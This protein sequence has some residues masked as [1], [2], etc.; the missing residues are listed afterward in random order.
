MTDQ[1][2]R[3]LLLENNPDDVR[4]MRAA[5]HADEHQK[6]EVRQVGNLADGLAALSK[7]LPDAIL[8]NLEL[9]DSR[10]L[11]T[12]TCLQ[13]HVPQLPILVLAGSEDM[14]EAVRAVQSGAQDFLSKDEITGS[15]LQRSI[16]YALERKQ[17]IEALR[18][19]EER[20]RLMFENT[21]VGYHSLDEHGHILD[22]NDTW[23]EMLGYTRDEVL[24]R[25]FGDFLIPYQVPLFKKRF[26]I[27]IQSRKVIHDVDY[28]LQRKDGSSLDVVF[29]IQISRD[30]AGKFIRTYCGFL[31]VT[32]RK[33]ATNR[34]EIIYQ[35]LRSVNGQLDVHSLSQA[36]ANTIVRL[37]NYPHVCVT[38]LD[39]EHTSW[40]VSGAAGRLAAELGAVYPIHE[41]VI[42]RAFKTGKTQRV[43]DIL[44]DPNYVRDVSTSKAPA[45]RSEMVTLFRH[46][47]NILGALN[48]ESEQVN[49]FSDEDVILIE[50]L[51]DVIAL[52]LDNASLYEEAQQDILQRKQTE[53]ELKNSHSLL[54]ATLE[55]TAEGILVVDLKGNIVR[56][57]NKYMEIWNIPAAIL[58]K[59]K[60]EGILAHIKKLVIDPQS[61]ISSTHAIYADPTTGSFDSLELKNGRIIERLS[62]PHLLGGT[63]IGRV[64][65][66]RDV[67]ER[68]RV[69]E[70][71]AKLNKAVDSSNEVIFLTDLDGIITY[72]NP[73]F[74]NL[75]GYSAEEVV[76]K[77]TPRILK[78]GK[79][80]KEKYKD[81]WQTLL[82]EQTVIG[83]LVNKTRDGRL[84]TIESSV[85][86]IR[87]DQGNRIGFVA[88]QRDITQRKTLEEEIKR[89][90]EELERFFQ[91]MPDLVCIAS[92]D[93]YF[94]NLNSAWE[95]TLGFS[96]AELY[97]EPLASFIHPD[98]I[99]PTNLEIARQVA[100]N[101]TI[102]FINRYRCKDGSYKWL[103]WHA[104]PAVGGTDLYAV[105]RDITER[106][107]VEEALRE[108]ELQLRESQRVS[109]IGSYAM[110]LKADTWTSSEVLDELFGIP[111]NSEK[112]TTS[113]NDLVH[114][115]EK[116][117]MLD[118][119]LH[120]VIEAKKPFNKEYRIVRPG[121]GQVRWMWGLGSLSYDDNGTPLTMIGTIQDITE[122]KQAELELQ[123]SHSL[124]TTTI[125]STA[126]GILVVDLDGRISLANGRFANMWGIPQPVLD[127]HDDAAA[128]AY[129]MDKLKEP[130]DFIAKVQE[131]YATPAAESFDDIEFK[132]G[133]I[134]ERVSQPQ[135]QGDTI[136]GRVW[137]FRD[138]TERKQAEILQ[139][140]VYQ[141]SLAAETT[142]ALDDLYSTIH[143]IISSVMPSEN[144]YITLYDRRRDVL[145]FPYFKDTQDEPY[146]GEIQPGR[147]LTAYV[148]R[149]GKSLLCTQKVHD[150]LEH[151]G[152]IKLLG[153]PSAIWLGVPLIVE[154]KAIGVM[155]VQHY[156]DEKAYGLREQHMLEFVSTQV[157]IVISR[158]QAEQALHDSETQFRTLVEQLPAIVYI[159]DVTVGPGHT[160]YVSPQ[161]ET[162]LGITPGE[163]M[164][165][166][167]AVWLE[168]T[169]PGDHDRIL[170][171]YMRCYQDGEPVNSEY[172][173]VSSD[174][175]LVWI[176]D[177]A[178]LLRD[179]NGKPHSIHGVMYDITERKQA[180][181][182]QQAV[183]Q[184]ALATETT[185]SLDDLYPTIHEIITSVMPSENFYI[186]LFDEERNILNFPY[187]KDEVDEP[188][189]GE[190]KPGHGLTDYVLRTGKSLL[191]TQEVHDELE[192]KG[193]VKL[194]GVPSAIWLGVPL[195]ADEKVIGAM[196]V[197]HYT[198]AKAYGL[199]EQQM[200]EF[201]SSQV[202]IAIRRKQAEERL[203]LSEERFKQISENA[204]E[205]IWEVDNRGMYT[206][207]SPL[208][209]QK[210]GYTREEIVGKKHFYDFFTPDAR[211]NLKEAALAAFAMKQPFKDFINPNQHK[212]G[213]VVILETNGTP[214]LDRNGDLLGYRGAD[215][216]ITEREQAA[217]SLRSSEE[218]F[219]SLFNNMLEGY[220]YCQGIFEQGR[221]QDFIYLAVNDKFSELT[222]LNDVVGK[223]VSEV[224]PG[225]KETNP[226]I[227]D[228]YGRVALNG[229]PEKFESYFPN[230]EI[231]L[232]I[233][234]HSS[235]KGYFNAVIDNITEHKRSETLTRL[236]LVLL[237][238]SSSHSLE[239]ILQKTLDEVEDLTGSQ[240]GFY[241]F[242][243]QDQ[244]NLV[245][246]NWSTRTKNEFCKAEGQG[247]HYPTS[248]AG[249]WADCVFT[250]QPIIHNDYASLPNR[251][252][253]PEGHA[254]LI[255]ELVVP[256]LRGDKVVAVLGVGNKKTNYNDRDIEM[257]NYLADS[258]W[259]FVA[260]KMAENKIIESEA[261]YH[262][263]FDNVPDGV[264]RTTPEGKFLTVNQEAVRMLGF[265]S[266]EELMSA[267]ADQFY[268]DRE[269]RQK[270][271][272]IMEELGEVHN[273]EVHFRNKDG[274][275]M[276][277]LENAR[278]YRDENGKVLFYEG[279]LTDITERKKSET[280]RQTL[281]EI[282]QGLMVTDDLHDYLNVVH[283]AIAKVIYAENF[284]VILK[285]TETGLFED[286]YMV[287]QFDLPMPPY[288]LGKTLSAFVYRTGRPFL[289]D[290]ATFDLLVAQGEVEQVGTRSPS[291]LGVP[292]VASRETIGVMVVQ[293]YATKNRYTGHDVD[294]LTSIA[295]QVALAVKRKYAETELARMF[296]R[297]KRRVVRLSEL[298]VISA[299]LNSQHS[300]RELL[301]TLVL[302]AAALSNSPVSTIM[303]LDETNSEVILAEHT[304]L[305]N[306]IPPG[307]RIPIKALPEEVLAFQKGDPIIISNID[308]ELPS[309]RRVLVHPDV[310]SFSAYPLSIDGRVAGVFTLSNFAPHHPSDGEINA[311]QL[312]AR[313]ASA[314]LD[315]VRL[316]ES[317]NRNVKRLGS[318]RRVDMAI[319]S[320]FDLMLTLNILLEQVTSHLEVDAA[321]VLVF[322]QGDSTLKYTCGRG[323]RSQAL[324]FTNLRLGEGY[325]GRAAL[326]R[327]TIHIPD[328][329]KEPSELD[330]STS[331]G[332]EDF[333]SYWGVPLVGKGHIQGVLEVFHRQPLVV[334][335]EWIDFLETLAGQA[336]IAID[337]VHL[338]DTLE[339]SNA[340]LSMA[341][342]NT[343][344]G[345]ASALEMRDNETEGHTRR[346]AALTMKLAGRLGLHDQEVMFLRWGSLLHDI[347]KMGI[348]DNILLK[349]GPLTDEEWVTM[350]KHPQL[351]YEM[352][353][354]IAYLREAL[355]IPYCHHEKWD[356]SG[357]P[358]QLK[359]EQIPIS[360]RIFAIVDVWDALIS[361]RPYREAWSSDKTLEYIREQAGI[362]FDPKVVKA[363]LELIEQESL[364][365]T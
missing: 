365:L 306:S 187:F 171:E 336:A 246:Q 349:P 49:A 300:E 263:L 254:T 141:I 23:L 70:G 271:I 232:S 167:L 186:T 320:S 310:Q 177:Q 79:L 175:R 184:I 21:P 27:A 234:V 75:Y 203:R 58:E 206:F 126:D 85:N 314:A 2:I 202:A 125:E 8:V 255:R 146:M 207:T 226:E 17:S 328:I 76:G 56:Y 284:F 331:L 156:T 353:A 133:R 3:L 269:D 191:C 216:D 236:R 15:L 26:P 164:E 142:P 115:E 221:L 22:I 139:Q 145:T 233:N 72:I 178:Q 274:R 93:G 218:R 100:G 268:N 132:D 16:R 212:D 333:V 103:E 361:D 317:I 297:E 18:Q 107:Q 96:L 335:Q 151:K 87:D 46:G 98:D 147:G 24:G 357:Y 163:W 32:E 307:M 66:I 123:A 322:D 303:L 219:R 273:L 180:E 106:K 239:E 28:T 358:R 286:T 276:V 143:Q 230:L 251:K 362:H 185:R 280:E 243:D 7:K 148:L 189:V 71:L 260:R 83:E 51:A 41:G 160:V 188:Y 119:F 137:I 265:D 344:A 90:K 111:F 29:T 155:V 292:L 245:L 114:P 108:S 194:L 220:T 55:S 33:Q 128:L 205:W 13:S 270:F 256:I 235:E 135:F 227:F 250:K 301:H 298:Q 159:D 288:E 43:R 157:A 117:A 138:I 140:A 360:A 94:K 222:G 105:A 14:Q 340:D 122:R 305:P 197:Q 321:D 346:V 168:H 312:L 341:Y 52:A 237:E 211:E 272:K 264:Y 130:Q 31:D 304:G 154:S 248:R 50:S 281:L 86:P 311:Y 62:Q 231:W 342:D 97:S 347:G 54:E 291:W 84:I 330:K 183:Y 48:I 267:S 302:R 144:F 104:T 73:E 11:E 283:Q 60:V 247:S 238:Y 324:R 285:N 308:L 296:E 1:K 39:K 318:L 174:G 173:M 316:F 112:T 343:L 20:F 287:D 249:V 354:P 350:R 224:I 182:L 161:I 82:N 38:T 131:L 53:T 217:L 40:V 37:T 244:E 262:S 277:L 109:R 25:W 275:D 329:H 166:D 241:H 299:D 208:V 293:D 200:L 95:K 12:F 34:Q 290:D 81:F 99:E 279:T 179:E 356:G 30:E 101:S 162:I 364:P 210:L 136:V 92:T 252:G 35:V 149:T 42:G 339:R 332:S 228:V 91:I 223:K 36:A 6:Y 214:L 45:L 10:G 59:G 67:T 47:K 327:R 170:A 355:D 315:N 242:V 289:F 169:Q 337:N 176:L 352:L 181:L 165:G 338:F 359:G 282:I 19:N 129:V 5:L 134:F 225:I 153:V 124:L 127:R 278:A 309:L 348:P 294:F 88:I 198:D 68:R 253:M 121:D 326:E 4:R 345:W 325:A 102:N 64:W 120:A 258:A 196:V 209:E 257:V 323:F 190:M 240:I 193:E 65:S 215:I 195:I 44:E 63:I 77:T 172:C 319:S 78:S 80:K 69:E 295:G 266:V 150:E 334:E 74:T 313:L 61:F 89:S 192:R 259:E 57:N 110:D 9:P 201:V 116:Q 118:Y 229:I 213:H 199:H 363:F 152:E 113:W 158:K 204:G 351:A 261:K